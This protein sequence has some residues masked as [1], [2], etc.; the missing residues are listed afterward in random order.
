MDN[1]HDREVTEFYKL[2]YNLYMYNINCTKYIKTYFINTKLGAI[3]PVL[4]YVCEL[5]M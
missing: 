4:L 2:A 5:Y 1:T 3:L